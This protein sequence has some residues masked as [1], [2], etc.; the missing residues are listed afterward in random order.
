MA[1]GN[2]GHRVQRSRV[3][4]H[5]PFDQD[6]ETVRAKPRGFGL[7]HRRTPTMGLAVEIPGDGLEIDL[8]GKNEMRHQL[9]RS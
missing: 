1:Q 6:R 7:E 8:P 5:H 4:D 2:H 9:S 3:L